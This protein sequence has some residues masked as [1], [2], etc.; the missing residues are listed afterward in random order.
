MT[1]E[2]TCGGFQRRTLSPPKVPFLPA[3]QLLFGTSSLYCPQPLDHLCLSLVR[4]ADTDT[5]APVTAPL[6]CPQSSVTSLL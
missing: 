1:V 2:E 6:P 4:W 5:F 3:L